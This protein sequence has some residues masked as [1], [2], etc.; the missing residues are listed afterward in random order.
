MEILQLTLS[1]LHVI[2]TQLCFAI[3]VSEKWSWMISVKYLSIRRHGN[4]TSLKYKFGYTT[5]LSRKRIRKSSHTFQSLCPSLHI[6]IILYL[7][8]DSVYSASGFI[9]LYEKKMFASNSDNVLFSFE[10][11]WY[12]TSYE[13]CLTACQ[14]FCFDRFAEMIFSQPAFIRHIFLLHI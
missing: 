11:F 13:F 12:L 10:D 7:Y 14:V 4:K 5:F 6:L 1:H 8:F 9:C 2:Y 3:T